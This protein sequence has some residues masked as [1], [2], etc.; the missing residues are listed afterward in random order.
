MAELAPRGP[1]STGSACRA[2]PEPRRLEAAGVRR[3][4]VAPF[5]GRAAAVEA[6]LGAALPPPGASG[7][8]PGGRILWVGLGLWLVEGERRGP[9]RQAA[10]SDQS[11]AWAGL[12]LDRR[13]CA[14]GAGAA[15]AARPRRGGLPAGSGGAQPAPARA[16]AASW[17]MIPASSCWCRGPMPGTA[18]AELATAMQAVAARAA[19]ARRG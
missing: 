9:R 5:A 11:D 12:R 13:R 19:L 15:G 17:P 6:A 18:V 8:W 1:P 16:A 10:A 4:A 2:R 3:T 7:G 14:G